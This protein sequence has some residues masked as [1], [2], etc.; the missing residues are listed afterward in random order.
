MSDLPGYT[1]GAATFDI[2]AYDMDGFMWRFVIDWGDGS[3]NDV[4][5][6]PSELAVTRWRFDPESRESTRVAVTATTATATTVTATR[7]RG[8]TATPG[9]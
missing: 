4:V 5:L 6:S 9:A 1:P 3:S 2:G 8:D 7:R